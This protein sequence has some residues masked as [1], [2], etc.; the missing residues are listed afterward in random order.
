MDDAFDGATLRQRVTPPGPTPQ[1][2]SG[3]IGL[4]QGIIPWDPRIKPEM[5][6]GSQEH[7]P[8]TT[9]PAH[10]IDTG[11]GRPL[12]ADQ[13]PTLRATEHNGRVAHHPSHSMSM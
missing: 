10:D 7:R 6:F 12:H 4:P 3:D 5:V 9:P 2:G 13:V 11:C 1:R 8:P